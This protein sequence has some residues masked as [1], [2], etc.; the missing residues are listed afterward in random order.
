MIPITPTLWLPEREIDERFIRASGPGG[1]NVN[2]VAT[3]VQLR[4][5]VAGSQALPADV[6]ARLLGVADRRVNSEGVLIITA[7]R[8][9]TREQNRRDARERLVH[10]IRRATHY[11]VA[12][13]ATRPSAAAKRRRREDKRHRSRTKQ[14]R[15]APPSGE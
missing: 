12:R 9:R 2:K 13:I 7:R 5:D 6:R 10:W 8:F 14:R 1:Q 4:F 11:P 15:T 3:A